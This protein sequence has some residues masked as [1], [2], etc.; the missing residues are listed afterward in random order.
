MLVKETKQE[1]HIPGNNKS[2]F[3]NVTLTTFYFG[4]YVHI[5]TSVRK[6]N[7]TG[8]SNVAISRIRKETFKRFR[9]YVNRHR[10]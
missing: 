6:E 2:T 8:N 9:F 10:K 3:W 5:R 7:G 4:I 1:R